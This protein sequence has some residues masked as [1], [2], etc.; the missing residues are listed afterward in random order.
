MSDEG[1][2][3][4]DGELRRHFLAAMRRGD[5]GQRGACREDGQ[6]GHRG[7]GP[8][9]QVGRHDAARG[10]AAGREGS[11]EA[12]HLADEVAIR[13]LDAQGVV[14]DGDGG[15]IVVRRGAQQ[16]LVEPDVGDLRIRLDAPELHAAS[17][18]PSLREIPFV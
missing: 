8:A 6:E 9:R 15:R 2:R 1:V 16:E 10:H 5:E 4:G 12:T 18:P 3:T 7:V 13:E 11:G 14:K 17:W